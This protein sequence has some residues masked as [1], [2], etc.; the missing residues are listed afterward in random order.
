MKQPDRA[1]QEG[2]GQN[3]RA[4]APESSQGWTW[5]NGELGCFCENVCVPV[6]ARDSSD[7]PSPFSFLS[8]SKPLTSQ[9]PSRWH[10]FL[11]EESRCPVFYH[12][13][14]GGICLDQQCQ[15]TLGQSLSLLDLSY[16]HPT[17][18]D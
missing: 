14:F 12:N 16:L 18:L 10:L 17:V 8:S 3:P 2:Y 11:L 7:S 4:A 6:C 15:V 9:Q 1:R 5:H 13:C